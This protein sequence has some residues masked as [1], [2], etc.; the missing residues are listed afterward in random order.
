MRSDAAYSKDL[1][2]TGKT[3]DT[4][5]VGMHVPGSGFYGRWTYPL[6]KQGGDGTCTLLLRLFNEILAK[7]GNLPRVLLLMLD[8]TS[9]ENKNNQVMSFLAYLVQQGVFDSVQV[10]KVLGGFPTCLNK[11]FCFFWCL[12]K[13]YLDVT[14]CNYATHVQHLQAL[15]YLSCQQDLHKNIG[16]GDMC[17]HIAGYKLL[18]RP[19]ADLI[20]LLTLIKRG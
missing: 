3:L 14:A 15:S 16:C 20:C 12:S 11:S 13:C 19:A 8:N 9:K 7:Q 10:K 18:L 2:S 4:R 6:F 5:L 1:D 17:K